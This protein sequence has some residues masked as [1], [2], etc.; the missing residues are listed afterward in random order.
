MRR[1]IPLMAALGA[2]PA[3]AETLDDY[4]A[5]VRA[6]SPQIAALDADLRVEVAR[7]SRAEVAYRPTVVTGFAVRTKQD[8]T[9]PTP[10]GVEAGVW[11]TTIE[12][13]LYDFGARDA[14]GRAERWRVTAAEAR[15]RAK[16]MSALGEAAGLYVALWKANDGVSSCKAA[17][18]RIQ[19]VEAAVKVRHTSRDASD[20]ELRVI[21][22]ELAGIR[23]QCEQLRADLVE[24]TALVQRFG[25]PDKVVEPATVWR[26]VEPAA[27]AEVSAEVLEAEAQM[28]A[29]SQEI[30]AAQ[31]GGLPTLA[32][33][34]SYDQEIQKADADYEFGVRVR[35][36]LFDSRGHD[37]DRRLAAAERDA[38]AKRREAARDLIE[39]RIKA[40]SIQ[41]HAQSF[42]VKEARKAVA[43]EKQRLVDA[44]N[45]LNAA[46]APASEVAQAARRLFTAK[47]SLAEAIAARARALI[48]HGVA[49]S[50]LGN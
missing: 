2:Y 46:K 4:L 37:V 31:R 38:A 44:E 32:A 39:A 26:E 8:S 10:H 42:V 41:V 24:A 50:T 34:G 13:P 43:I 36:D 35:A 18:E 48:Q 25:A 29:A 28:E 15:T 45:R 16:I 6:T 20:A 30:I 9:L 40:A 33:Y 3:S 27:A 7:N 5:R 1:L 17:A 11:Q 19:R 23:V 12:V 21:T 47:R 22:S 14:R 49:T